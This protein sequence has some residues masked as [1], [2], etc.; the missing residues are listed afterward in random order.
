MTTASS[1]DDE[2]T[3]HRFHGFDLDRALRI[4]AW[5]VTGLALLFLVLL[6]V[7]VLV[8]LPAGVQRKVTLAQYII[9]IVLTIDFF[10]RLALARSKREY[11]R[12]NW[13]SALALIFPPF[14]VLHAVRAVT[15]LSNAGRDSHELQHLL[16]SGSAAYVLTLSGAIVLVCAAGMYSIESSVPGANITSISDAL[17]W[18]SSTVTTI[19]SEKYPVTNEGRAL[20]VVLMIYALAFGGYVTATLAVLLLGQN[21]QP[22]SPPPAPPASPDTAALQAQLTALQ[23]QVQALTDQLTAA[24]GRV[25]TPADQSPSPARREST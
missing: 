7:G 25:A 12:R 9:W 1:T 21:Q 11:L 15:L 18:A 22:A 10:L 6:L 19:G 14:R 16:K 17:W 8:E 24:N 23:G 3:T 2:I 5:A 13:F 4:E 20:A